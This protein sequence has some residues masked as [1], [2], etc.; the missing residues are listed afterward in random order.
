MVGLGERTIRTPPPFKTTRFQETVEG[1]GIIANRQ[2]AARCPKRSEWLYGD[3]AMNIPRTKEFEGL[4]MVCFIFGLSCGFAY[5]AF[6]VA[7]SS[8]FIPAFR[9]IDGAVICSVVWNREFIAATLLAAP[10]DVQLSSGNCIHKGGNL[11]SFWRPS[12]VQPR[13]SVR[14]LALASAVLR[15]HILLLFR[16]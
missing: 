11:I 12:R 4:R 6:N 15:R 3:G 5:G 10:S 9:A 8:E 16:P 13:Q 2:K 7:P 14:D 1:E